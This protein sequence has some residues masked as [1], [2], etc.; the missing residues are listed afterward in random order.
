MAK[1]QKAAIKPKGDSESFLVTFPTDW[2]IKGHA[3]K[4]RLFSSVQDFIRELV[5]RD[6]AG[7]DKEESSSQ[8]GSA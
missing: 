1:Q 7:L 4:K 3:E 2:D 8:N 5:R 6:I